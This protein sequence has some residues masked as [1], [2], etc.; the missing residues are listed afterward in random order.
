MI[1]DKLHYIADRALTKFGK[2]LA[3]DTY[4]KLRYRLDMGRKLNLK[5]PTLFTE[6]LQW[7]KAYYHDPLYTKLVD[8]YEVKKWVADKIGSQYVIPLYGV[9][10]DFNEIDFDK[11]PNSFIL[12]T[13]HTS[14]GFI[15]CKDKAKFDKEGARK[16]M[17]LSLHNDYYWRTREW[18]YKNV[19]KRIIA[20]KYMPSLGNIDSEEYKITC[21]NGKV[22]VFTVCRGVP[23]SDYALRH[24]DNF[25]RNFNRQKWYAFY[26]PSDKPVEKPAKFDEMIE[27]AE[28][29]AEGIP[30]VRVDFYVIDGQIYFG[31]MTFFTWAGF[32]KFTPE[33]QDTVMGKWIDLPDHKIL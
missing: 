22:K 20:E 30:T 10:N 8:K 7:L 9:W 15:V 26:T 17:E 19:Q 31:E 29:L 27:L 23:H 32:I 4:L 24:N 11:L 5:S 6:K 18:P 1:K 13:T 2:C 14:G 21:C 25:D 3:D 12:K 16:M 28:K 33:S